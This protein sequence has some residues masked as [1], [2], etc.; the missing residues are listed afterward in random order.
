MT[1]D[2]SGDEAGHPEDAPK[3]RHRV[4]GVL[5][6]F[7]C[8]MLLCSVLFS[9]ELVSWTYDLPE[10]RGTDILVVTA[11]RWAALIDESGIAE[12]VF[13]FRENISDLY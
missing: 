2:V 6:I 4:L 3:L 7:A 1:K 13:L 10:N 9:G 5:T 8:S 11:E 12:S